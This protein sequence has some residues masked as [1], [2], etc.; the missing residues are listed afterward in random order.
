MG[1]P[2][3]IIPKSGDSFTLIDQWIDLDSEG[4]IIG[5]SHLPGETLTFTDDTFRWDEI[6]ASPGVYFIGFFIE[7]LDGNAFPVYTKVTVE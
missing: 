6:Y 3:E 2:R 1:A 5:K 4:N 7:D